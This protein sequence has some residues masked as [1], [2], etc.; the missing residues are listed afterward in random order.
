LGIE[1]AVLVSTA[2]ALATATAEGPEI[3]GAARAEARSES[4]RDKL[5]V[6]ENWLSEEGTASPRDVQ[7][8]LGNGMAATESC[9][10]AIYLGARFLPLPFEELLRFV[11]AVG[12]DA[13][14]IGAMAGA[15]WGGSH[16]ASQ[17]PSAMLDR[18]EDRDR[19]ARLARALHHRFTDDGEST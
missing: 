14:T 19:I 5:L 6:A 7:R 8:E 10:T 18:L 12:G 1:G 3:L 17:L 11:A 2:V 4:F 13:D 16:G 15:I 9:V